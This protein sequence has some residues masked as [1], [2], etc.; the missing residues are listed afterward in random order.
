MTT[1]TK[2]ITN[3]II[4]AFINTRYQHSTPFINIYCVDGGV[5]C[6]WTIAQQALKGVHLT[7]VLAV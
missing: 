2:M 3:T 7:P 6:L 1:V 5:E 4:N